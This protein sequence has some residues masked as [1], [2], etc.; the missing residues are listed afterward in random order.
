[1]AW[2]V[3][4]RDRQAPA[5]SADAMSEQEFQDR[6]VEAV[7]KTS[8]AMLDGYGFPNGLTHE[9]ARRFHATYLANF[10]FFAWK[11]PSWL[12]A[13]A[14]QCPHQDVRRGIIEDCVDEEV[15]D[16]DA[17]GRCHVDVL[18]DEAEACGIDRKVIAQLEPSPIILA[19]V[20]AFENLAN[21][22]GWEASFAAI[23]ALEIMQAEPAVKLRN[24]I[25]GQVMTKEEIE[26]NKSARGPEGLAAATG[27]R[28]EQLMFA[29]LHAY[30]D[31]FHGG[32]ELA[33]LVKYAT[34]RETQ[35]KMLWAAKAGSQV[36]CVMR[37]E[38][39]RLARE[40]VGA[41]PAQ[42]SGIYERMLEKGLV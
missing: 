20:H 6:F 5:R 33:M 30:K 1:M 25:L 28:P 31:Q 4:G 37:Q 41:G 42:P 32:G 39:N 36:Y 2:F 17:G 10:S 7:T 12:M 38:I 13:I 21:S 22:L 14:S 29:A 26:A 3:D 8:M 24:Q 18:Y 11:F 27:L 40:A 23:A 15:A 9:Q 35:E 16:V 19:C 34:T